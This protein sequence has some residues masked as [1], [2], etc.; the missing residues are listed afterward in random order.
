MLCTGSGWA[1]P[2]T[3]SVSSL[4]GNW[5][6]NTTQFANE[7]VVDA[8]PFETGV[9]V[10]TKAFA[11]NFTTHTDNDRRAAMPNAVGGKTVLEISGDAMKYVTYFDNTPMVYTTEFEYKIL[12]VDDQG[13]SG[14]SFWIAKRRNGD[15]MPITGELIKLSADRKK[16]NEF[17]TVGLAAANAGQCF[18]GIY[19]DYTTLNKLDQCPDI[20]QKV[21]L[22]LSVLMYNENLGFEALSDVQLKEI[23]A[24]GQAVAKAQLDAERKKYVRKAGKCLWV[25]ALASFDGGTNIS[26]QEG[27]VV[28]TSV[29]GGQVVYQVKFFPHGAPAGYLR[30]PESRVLRKSWKK[31]L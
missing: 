7:D 25:T 17:L 28:G 23:A 1:G 24:K 9:M 29:Q 12:R 30:V 27:L 26:P 13:N 21:P 19:N 14:T 20:T 6:P 8:I 10:T 15:G 3:D 11:T 2:Q 16:L 5:K 31:C 22:S 4:A 18:A